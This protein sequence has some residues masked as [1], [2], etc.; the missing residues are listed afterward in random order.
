MVP[1]MARLQAIDL[2]LGNW[3]RG[4]YVERRKKRSRW[5]DKK[6]RSKIGTNQSES[7]VIMIPERLKNVKI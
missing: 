1:I 6:I 4:M 2:G 3:V 5:V 7:L